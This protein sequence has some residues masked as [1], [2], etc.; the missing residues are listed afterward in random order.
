MWVPLGYLTT[1]RS[2]PR[3]QRAMYIMVRKLCTITD[4]WRSSRA[5]S[6]VITRPVQISSSTWVMKG[7]ALTSWVIW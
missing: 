1:T 3:I 5:F 2:R 6:L 4:T 7:H